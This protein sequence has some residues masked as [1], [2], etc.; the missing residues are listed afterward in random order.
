MEYFWYI[1]AS[2]AAGVGTGLAGLSAATVMVPVLIVLCPSF[3]GESGAYHATA[4]ALASDIL[5]SAVTAGIYIKHKNIDLRRG[6]L[7]M[8]CILSM[9]VAGSFVAFS[10]GSIVLGSFSLFLTFFI[11]IRFLFKPDSSHSED[12]TARAGLGIKGILISLFFGLTIG[13]GTGFVGSGGGMMMLLVFTAFLGMN[14]KSAVGTSTF[15][16]TFTALIAAVSHILIDP[17]I[18]F[19]QWDVLLICIVTAT[20]ASLVSAQFANRVKNRTVGLATGALLTVLGATMLLM[21]YWDTISAIPLILQVLKCL[22]EFLEYILAGAVILIILRFTCKKLPS[23]VFRKLLHLVA[24]TSVMEVIL[25]T[26]TWYAAVITVLIFTAIVFPVLWV[27]EGCDWY[28]RL[29]VQKKK[30][31]IKKSMVFLFVMTA[32]VIAFA[33][34]LLGK[35]YIALATTVMWGCGDAVAALV[36][37]RYGKHKIKWRFADGKKTWEGSMAMLLTA[38]AA[39]FLCLLLASGQAW[40]WCMLYSAIAAPIC[41]LT[42]LVSKDGSDTITVPFVTALA[43]FLLTL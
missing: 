38:F 31:E 40:Y 10:V 21:H 12:S 26:E 34:G 18:F 33:W 39:G 14:L 6:W 3:A 22:V 28:G 17:S 36:G 42:E 35:E 19:E 5:G 4:I 15:I 27:L 16:M 30:G 13:F 24:F 25:V 29:F 7:M 9:C 37:I 20:A 32:L 23:Y 41:A 11:G 8:T 43:L 1:V 2:I